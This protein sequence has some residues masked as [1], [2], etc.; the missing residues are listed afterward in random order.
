MQVRTDQVLPEHVARTRDEQLDLAVSRPFVH[1]S[2]AQR[3]PRDDLLELVAG[4]HHD[5]NLDPN[6]S[7][8]SRPHSRASSSGDRSVESTTLPLCT[9]V[10]T[11]PN[12]A[13]VS[14]SRRAGIAIR[15]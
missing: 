8:T 5:A 7:T 14:S 13:L 11:S 1:S 9:Y 3:V 2:S 15:L 6:S 10:R 4:A 12:P